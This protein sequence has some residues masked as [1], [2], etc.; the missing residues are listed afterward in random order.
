MPPLK[1]WLIRHGESTANAGL[2]ATRDAD[3]PMTDRGIAQSR[4][5]AQM[6]NLV[7]D[8]LIISP[9]LRARSTAE[10]IKDRWPS[11]TSEIWPIQEFTYLSHAR[12]T[13][14]TQ[15]ERQPFTRAYWERSDPEYVDGD[16]AESFADFL[17]RLQDFH[18]RLLAL[19]VSFAVVVGHGQFF[20]A[21]SL[22]LGHKI[23]PSPEGMKFYRQSETADSLK[24]GEVLKLSL[25][26]IAQG[27]L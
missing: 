1:T 19:E 27:C 15:L 10:F 5:V 25:K 16:D 6:I 8:I 22:A 24:N 26:D 7:P 23:V 21:Y 18:S 13:G 11:V 2:P 9:S 3:S 20:R 14:T 4:T 12:C 17:K